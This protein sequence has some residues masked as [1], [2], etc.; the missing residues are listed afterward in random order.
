MMAARNRFHL[1]IYK[2]E[3]MAVRN[4]ITKLRQFYIN[5]IDT[6]SDTKPRCLCLSEQERHNLVDFGI[7]SAEIAKENLQFQVPDVKTEEN[8]A[9]KYSREHLPIP[10]WI[11]YRE[12]TERLRNSKIG[13]F[14][15]EECRVYK[16][17]Y[18]CRRCKV[19]GHIAKNRRL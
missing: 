14:S 4:G 12:A 13:K 6:F 19:C 3:W 1:P 17:G 18:L 8:K 11:L 10:N 15:K 16:L 7:L 2:L 9:D 5:T